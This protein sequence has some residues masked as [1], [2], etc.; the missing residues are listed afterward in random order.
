M[1]FIGLCCSR[2]GQ[3]SPA[4]IF[5]KYQPTLSSFANSYDQFKRDTPFIVS[6]NAMYFAHAINK[7]ETFIFLMTALSIIPNAIRFNFANYN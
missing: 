3:C 5:N 2:P 4:L 6:G 1:Y 7:H